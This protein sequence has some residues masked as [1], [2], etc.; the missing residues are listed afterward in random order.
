MV[1]RSKA[2]SLKGKEMKLRRC[3][4]S[5]SLNGKAKLGTKVLYVF[6]LSFV[7]I[8]ILHQGESVS[9]EEKPTLEIV[10]SC[11]SKRK[12]QSTYC[13]SSQQFAPQY[14]IP[15]SPFTIFMIYLRISANA[16]SLG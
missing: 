3:H 4:D 7:S 14:S 11:S 13:K 9:P 5:V 10:R 8:R 2:A 15:S 6:N 12:I 1:I 16:P